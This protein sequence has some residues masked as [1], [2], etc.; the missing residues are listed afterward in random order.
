MSRVTYT[1][2]A[3]TKDQETLRVSHGVR[4]VT[5]AEEGTGVNALPTGVYGYTYSPG[6][7]NAPLFA[8]RRFRAFETH[9]TATDAYLTG[10]ASADDAAM[11]HATSQEATITILPEPEAGA[12]VLVWVPYARIHRHRQYSAPNE[13][14]FSLTILPNV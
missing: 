5:S 2:T 12:D 8:T 3:T 10:F 9:K 11:L 4:L 14:G 7:A 13:K 6:L 1:D